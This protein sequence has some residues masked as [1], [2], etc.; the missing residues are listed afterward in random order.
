MKTPLPDPCPC[1][2]CG[3][4]ANQDAFSHA[5]T[6]HLA[7]GV[8]VARRILRS[9]D[10]A[11]DAVQDALLA[12]WRC[13]RQPPD[14]RGWIVRAVVHRALSL[15]RARRRRASHEQRASL[16]EPAD[17]AEILLH[18]ERHEALHVAIAAL[19]CEH[20]EVVELCDLCG[21]AYEESAR[22]LTVPVGTV[23]SRLHRARRALKEHLAKL[24][25]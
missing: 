12:L 23:R 17:P 2:I 19:S 22:V 24:A 21:L 11:E 8:R 5:V 9:P 14:L 7:A 3:A 1:P 15:A 20:R 10:L 25:G 4:F 6:P 18:R 16:D 13:D